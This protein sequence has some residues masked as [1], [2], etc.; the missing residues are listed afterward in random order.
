MPKST[1]PR[2]YAVVRVDRA[3][4]KK[5]Q[6]DV[7]CADCGHLPEVHGKHCRTC[8]ADG[9]V[10]QV[11]RVTK[12]VLLMEGLD[13]PSAED[14]ALFLEKSGPKGSVYRAMPAAQVPR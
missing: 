1:K 10:C 5:R 2:R 6:H 8:S 11:Y 7:P 3:P 14:K 4:P 13:M 12:L 9:K